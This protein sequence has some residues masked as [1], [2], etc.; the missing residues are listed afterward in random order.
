[1]LFTLPRL[2]LFH[3]LIAIAFLADERR[4]RLQEESLFEHFP[5]DGM[6]AS[7]KNVVGIGENRHETSPTDH[8]SDFIR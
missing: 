7:R 5:R 4:D 3:Y 8:V 1:M 2:R 6:L